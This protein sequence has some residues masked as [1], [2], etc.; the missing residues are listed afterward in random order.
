MLQPAALRFSHRLLRQP[1]A[2]NAKHQHDCSQSELHPRTQKVPVQL[3]HPTALGAVVRR[4]TVSALCQS[5]VVRCGHRQRDPPFDST[6]AA[7]AVLQL[8]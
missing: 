7:H 3:L 1:T 6:S 2:H 8:C 4:A 5:F